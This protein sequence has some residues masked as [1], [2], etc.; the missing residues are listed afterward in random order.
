MDITRAVFIKKY[1]ILFNAI[2]KRKRVKIIR[3]LLQLILYFKYICIIV[4]FFYIRKVL[5]DRWKEEMKEK[6]YRRG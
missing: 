3:Q 5:G 1:F 4:E 6:K 2:L